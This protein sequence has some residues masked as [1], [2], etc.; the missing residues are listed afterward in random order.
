M[1]WRSPAVPPTLDGEASDMRGHGLVPTWLTVA[2][3]VGGAVAWSSVVVGDVAVEDRVVVTAGGIAPVA[4]AA[5]A[6]S[7]IASQPVIVR[8]STWYLRS[9]LSSGP[10]TTTFAFG[11][12]YAFPLS[13]D[14]NGAGTPTVGSVVRNVWSLRNTNS[15]GAADLT[16]R[17]GTAG[18]LPI[19]GDWDGDGDDTPGV[20][21]GNTWYLRNSATSGAAD[22]TLRYGT[23]G[24]IPMA[25]DW[26]GDGDDTPG[27]RRGNTWYLRDAL[28]TGSANLQVPYGRDTDRPLV[29]DWDG[30]GTTTPGVV[31]ANTWLL[32][33]DTGTTADVTFTYGSGCE[34]ALANTAALA[35]GLGGTAAPAALAGQDITV[36]PTSRK[37]VAL[38]FDAGANADAVPSILQTLASTCTPATFF[39]TGAWSRDFPVQAR[40]ISQRY[41]VGN[42]TDSHPDLTTLTDAQVRSQVTTAAAEVRAATAYDTRPLFRFPFGAR[43]ARTIGIVNDL[44]YV[45]VRWTVDTLG[46]Q[47]TS[48]G[49]SVQTVV[50]RVINGARNGEIVLMHVGSNPDDGSTLDA[51]ALPTIISE[52]TA[53][54]YG[55][56]TL[57][58]LL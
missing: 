23:G 39:L 5:P 1:L 49:Q 47:G 15:A 22:V 40:Q 48:G 21:R 35:R 10:A 54:G 17:Y 41:P 28:S 36:L 44:G 58:E 52:L 24:D 51:A 53:R 27:I 2:T 19:I 33:N 8:G 13:G 32:S 12:A 50:N 29:G 25:G 18:D 38:T 42:H 37:V 46:W 3:L 11:N 6:A 20:V 43:N 14:W 31:R 30:N 16:F 56:V 4:A 55:F 57:P 34:V 26:D 45:G 9:S 7:P